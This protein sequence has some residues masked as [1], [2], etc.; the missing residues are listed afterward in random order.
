MKEEE[1]VR[2][3]NFN[4]LSDAITILS[5]VLPGEEFCTDPEMFK[6]VMIH[7]TD[8]RDHVLTRRKRKQK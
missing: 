2:V 6:E 5:G 1:F 3:S 8:L 7:L 4:K